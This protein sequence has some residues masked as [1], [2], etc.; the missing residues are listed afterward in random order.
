MNKTLI[1]AFALSV[2]AIS[3]NDIFAKKQ[4]NFI[5]ILMDD[6]GYGD[7]RANGAIG[8][9]T[10]NID[11]MVNEGMRF[12]R[13][14]SPQAVSGASRA[15]LLTGCY[16]N[17]IGISGAPGPGSET[18]INENEMTIAEVLKPKGYTCAAYGKWHLGD[19]TQFLP[20][21][22]GFDEYYGIP[23]SNDMWPNHPT[24]KFPSLP[25]IEGDKTIELDPDQSR[26]TTDF[27]NRA[28]EFI[29]KNK[30]N[31]FFPLP[32]SSDASCSFVCLG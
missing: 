16:P 6:M 29:G 11:R 12:T 9:E 2:G 24:Y 25:L 21:H 20:T 4:P 8:Y 17:R 28:V 32:G 1:K 23:Y 31:P 15:G 22:N 18:G 5:V 19:Q 3:A 30:K 14:Y 26:F 10:P 13:F 27:T 7:L